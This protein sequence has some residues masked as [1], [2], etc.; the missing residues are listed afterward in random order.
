MDSSVI[1]S[2]LLKQGLPFVAGLAS[3]ALFG[4]TVGPMA[5]ATRRRWNDP[6]PTGITEED[7][8]KAVKLPESYHD[9]IRWLGHLERLG[10]FLALWMGPGYAIAIAG[11]LTFKV[12]SKWET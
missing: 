9:P 8:L 6:A 1:Y 5:R 3:T 4:L 11:W 2:V 10:Y 7:W 12:A